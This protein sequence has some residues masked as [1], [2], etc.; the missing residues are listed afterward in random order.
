ML[1][2]S[3]L[4]CILIDPDGKQIRSLDSLDPQQSQPKEPFSRDLECRTP[5]KIESPATV[6]PFEQHL[7]RGFVS[8]KRLPLGTLSTGV[9]SQ[10]PVKTQSGG[11][12]QLKET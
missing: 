11:M 7:T 2:V 6:V 9:S 5:P 1:S 12:P 4:L 3:K 8:K 10:F